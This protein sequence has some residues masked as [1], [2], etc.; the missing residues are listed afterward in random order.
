MLLRCF[1]ALVV[2]IVCLPA[3]AE[4][5]R[6]RQPPPP[7]EA[8]GSAAAVFSGKVTAIEFQ[9][10]RRTIEFEV[11]LVWKGKPG[12]K[13]KIHTADNEAACGY[14]FEVGGEYLVYCYKD[15]D[16]SLAT[17]L[18]TRTRTLAEAAT[19]DLPALGQGAMP[20]R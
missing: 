9:E 15:R 17:N 19:E 5:C 12:A 1:A 14:G 10:G 4:A 3:L 7:K 8:A 6:C 2:A 20:G 13:L 16:G 18:C 11:A